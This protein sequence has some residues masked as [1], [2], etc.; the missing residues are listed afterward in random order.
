MKLIQ[1][2]MYVLLS[3]LL[4]Q[5]LHQSTLAA[6][7]TFFPIQDCIKKREEEEGLELRDPEIN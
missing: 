3:S 2:Y 6:F 1:I 7:F 4:S 5:E